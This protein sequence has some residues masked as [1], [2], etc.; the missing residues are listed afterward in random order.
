MPPRRAGDEEHRRE[1]GHVD[2]RGAEVG[3]D[4]DEERRHGTEQQ[5]RS[6]VDHVPITAWRSEMSPASA[7]MTR[8]FPN[9]DGW[10]CE[11]AEVDPARR[12]ARGLADEEDDRDEPDG[13]AVDEPPVA[14]VEVRVDERRDDEHEPARRGVEDLL[15]EVVVRAGRVVA[16]DRRRSPRAR[17]RRAPRVPAT[18]IQSNERT[19]ARRCGASRSRRPALCDPAY[20][21]ISSSRSGWGRLSGVKGTWKNFANTSSAAGAAA[22]PPWPPFSITAHTTSVGCVVRAVAA[23]PRLVLETG[24]VDRPGA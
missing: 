21:S 10:N 18:R 16:R 4:E 5:H 13:H 9:S 19:T 20:S 14:A 11:E 8:S 24:C 23:P 6:V 15:V 3:L 1:R 2:E 17:R 22:S 12:A 7:R